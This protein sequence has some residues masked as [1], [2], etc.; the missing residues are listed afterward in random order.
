[1]LWEDLYI[2]VD[3]EG[4]QE[5]SGAYRTCTTVLLSMTVNQ[6]IIFH[7]SVI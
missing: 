7:A 2:H 5:K 4:G 1:M 3:I 6:T